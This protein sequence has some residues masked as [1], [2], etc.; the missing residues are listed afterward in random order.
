MVFTEKELQKLCRE[1][2]K[3]LRL[4]DWDVKVFVKRESQFINENAAGEC[5]W[6]LAK[7]LA[8][9]RILDPID[10]GSNLAWPQDQEATLVH[11]LLHLHFAPFAAKDDTPEDTAQEQAIDLIARALV[12][13]KR[14]R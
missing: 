13:L 6:Q 14:G 11:E 10:Y 3:R 5:S 9:I 8:V 12:E 7:K 4:Q 2:Q 1:W